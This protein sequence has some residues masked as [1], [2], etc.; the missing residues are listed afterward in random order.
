[1]VEPSG[2]CHGTRLQIEARRG[3]TRVETGGGNWRLRSITAYTLSGC[4]SRQ[5]EAEA[6]SHVQIEWMQVDDKMDG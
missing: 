4:A 6:D 5:V 1:M 2:D 3:A